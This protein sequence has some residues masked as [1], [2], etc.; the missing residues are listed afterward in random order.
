MVVLNLLP[1]DWFLLLDI[2]RSPTFTYEGKPYPLEKISSMGNGYTFELESVIFYALAHSVCKYL[3]LPTTNVNSYGD[4]IIIPSAGYELLSKALSCLGFSVNLEKSFHEGPFRESC[5]KDFYLGSQVRPLF[6]KSK[7]SAQSLMY[8]CNH[9]RREQHLFP[10]KPYVD[11]YDSFKKLLPKPFHSL[12]GPDGF[13]DG[14]LIIPFSEYTGN[15]M[16]AFRRRGFEGVGFY[17]LLEKP[18]RFRNDGR[19]NYAEALYNAQN[20]PLPVPHIRGFWWGYSLKHFAQ[21][22]SLSTPGETC[23]RNWAGFNYKRQRTRTYLT[24]SFAVW[25][26]INPW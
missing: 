2:T 25:K 3:K 5:G 22:C 13:G 26:D 16:H 20:I 9:I 12:V 14:H 4:D 10:E 21:Q 18:V 24:K 6:L 11:L 17:T 7:P 19:S 1:I 23:P 8:W 15:R